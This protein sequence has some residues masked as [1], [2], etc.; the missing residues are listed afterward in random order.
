M[1]SLWLLLQT[2][3]QM[4]LY[5]IALL[6]DLSLPWLK[7]YLFIFVDLDLYKNGL[8]RSNFVPFIPILK[9]INIFVLFL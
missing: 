3:I 8:Q 4:V 1:E 2:D 7:N 6:I 9:V 5:D